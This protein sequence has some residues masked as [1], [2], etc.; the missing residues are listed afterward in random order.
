MK[1]Y[2]SCLKQEYKF[3][4]IKKIKINLKTW[5]E[6][7]RRVGGFSFGELAKFFEMQKNYSTIPPN[8]RI[9]VRQIKYWTASCLAVTRSDDK[10]SPEYIE[11]LNLKF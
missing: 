8:Y 1:D 9:F 7:I 3:L 10:D 5:Q 6:Y 11:F 4:Y 2:H